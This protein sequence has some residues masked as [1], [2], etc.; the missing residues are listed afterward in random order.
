MDILKLIK[1]RRTIRRYKN[2]PVPKKI[3]D[4]IIQAGIWG[5]SVPSFLRIQP[6][7]F[8]IVE[9]RQCINKAADILYK[10]SIHSKAGL[11]IMLRSTGNII[12]SASRIILVYRSSKELEHFKITWSQVY[13]NFE[14]LIKTAQLSAISA[15]IQNMILTAHAY[16]IASCWLDMPLLCKKELNSLFEADEE[17]VA[18]LTLGYAAEK[19][20][21]SSRKPFSET[22]EFI[23]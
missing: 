15:A 17:L 8:I 21:R 9:D 3:L 12:K 2:K 1:T 14:K 6:W 13:S 5:P 23:K 16:G 11:N 22:V 19:G 4:K 18:I 10:K 7:R 20:K